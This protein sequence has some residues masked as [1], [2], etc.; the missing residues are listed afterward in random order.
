DQDT[1]ILV[2]GLAKGGKGYYAL[3][4]TDPGLITTEDELADRV[5]WEYPRSGTDQADIDDLG[6][7]Y[8]RPAIVQTNNTEDANWIMIFGNGYNSINSHAVLFIMDPAD[9]NVLRKIDTGVGSC[10]GLSTPIAV[11][12]NADMK[13]DY[14]FAGD[15]KGN[16]WKFDLTDSDY[17][18]WSVAYQDV[19]DGKD[20]DDGTPRPV[21]KAKGP[22]G[23]GFDDQPITTKPEVIYHCEKHGYMVIVGTGKYLGESDF[24]DSRTQT[25]YGIWDYGDDDDDG[26]YIGSFER[27]STPQLSNQPDTVTLLQQ[28]VVEGDFTT[29]T[30]QSLRIL[31][32][33][34]PVWTVTTSDENCSGAEGDTP[35]DPDGVGDADPE[36]NVGW[37]FDLPDIGERVASDLLIR[38]GKAIQVSFIPE[39]SPCGTGGNSVIMEMDACTGGRLTEAQFDINNDGVIDE[40]DLIN[41][42]GEG[43]TP[44]WVAPTGITYPGHLQPPAILQVGEEE[45]KYFS[46]NV[47]TIVTLKEKGARLGIIYWMEFE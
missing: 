38:E 45:M 13:V 20:L 35:C 32:D 33:K 26:E 41:I 21:F 7:S 39:Y 6:F 10:N 16:L 37:Y 17:N 47:G 25:I 40:N 42:A 44:I 11:D 18:N 19:V 36:A 5:L 15:L 9:G 12:V 24:A 4:I 34:V 23:I 31:T 28:T 2:G 3:N 22:G 14:V 1:A 27:G 43:E 29:Q 30:G 46:T 8:S